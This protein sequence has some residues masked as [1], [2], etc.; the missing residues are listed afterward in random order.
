MDQIQDNN[1]K[2]INKNILSTIAK[3]VLL[4]LVLFV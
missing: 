1:I 3:I 2:N 4:A